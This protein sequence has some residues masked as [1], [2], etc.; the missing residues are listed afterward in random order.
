L[1]S[2]DGIVGRA[3]RG[4]AKMQGGVGGPRQ[5]ARQNH[6]AKSDFEI[7]VV[8]MAQPTSL[9]LLGAIPRRDYFDEEDAPLLERARRTR[10]LAQSVGNSCTGI[11]S[12]EKIPS[13]AG[14][15]TRI[16]TMENVT[17]YT[18]MKTDC[19]FGIRIVDSTYPGFNSTS[20]KN[21]A[22]VKKGTTKVLLDSLFAEHRE[23]RSE[24]GGA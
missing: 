1:S 22:P 16:A 14:M 5:R 3:E 19:V 2:P 20:V 7:L 13:S 6:A 12:S 11:L 9:K 23:N 4:A 18:E 21:T 8:K 17:L 15:P 24:S 10:A